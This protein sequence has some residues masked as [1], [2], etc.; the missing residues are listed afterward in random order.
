[1]RL[2]GGRGCLA[3]AAGSGEAGLLMGMVGYWRRVRVLV[4]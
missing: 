4:L 2:C 3:T 1:M